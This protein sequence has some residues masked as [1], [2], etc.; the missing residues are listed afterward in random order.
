M[1]QFR[2]LLGDEELVREINAWIDSGRE[3]PQ[4][5][6]WGVTG[7][8]AQR[9]LEG[10]DPPDAWTEAVVLSYARP[11]LRVQ[12]GHL[13]PPLS[14]ELRRRMRAALPVIE[15]R[16]RAVGRVVMS[17][18]PRRKTAGTA[19][20]SKSR[21]AITTADVAN[22]VKGRDAA[23]EFPDVRVRIE[24]IELVDADANVAV[25]RL[26]DAD[27]MPQPI[28][29]TLNGSGDVIVA[30]HLTPESEAV[31]LSDAAR[32]VA[33]AAVAGL[34][35]A[36]GRMSGN[37]HD[38]T[39]AGDATG[40]V[41]LDAA[42]GA[43]VGMHPNIAAKTLRA[44][45]K[46]Y[47]A[48][49]TTKAI[50][51]TV[52]APMMIEEAPLTP[53]D[54]LDRKGYDPKFLG[55]TPK[56]RVKLPASAARDALEFTFNGKRTTELKYVHFSVV[57]SESRQLCLFSAVNIDGKNG[58]KAARK[59][60]LKDPRITD[61]QQ[62]FGDV[63]GNSPRFSRG[64]MTRREDPIWGVKDEADKG[65]RDSMHFTNAV[66]QMQPFN[67]PV[68][69]ALEDYALKNARKDTQR[70]TVITGPFFRKDDPVKFG[71][72]IPV[73]FWK[74][75][76]FIHDETGELTCTGYTMSQEDFLSPLEFVFGAFK[77]AQV[78]VALIEKRAKLD[79]HGL[80]KRDPL[81]GEESAFV[82]LTD[83]RDVRFI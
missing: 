59:G 40:G 54:Y 47:V 73:E 75:I 23:I 39:I 49:A 48:V 6:S 77:E 1:S 4:A 50:P 61:E 25:L 60:W 21:Y 57:M 20:L 80:A 5:R 55:D 3:L 12:N 32:R 63:Y 52:E 33:G 22:D 34:Y 72:R 36:P 71:V 9:A 28:P 76:I 31:G 67:A 79:F 15:R 81:A 82:P 24:G 65:N 29:I 83:V 27:E 10:G 16:L 7:D 66:P 51:E 68:W 44:K 19:W 56:L 69:L 13:Q 26:E 30:A 18:H 2:S 45:A 53:A 14:P 62:V 8:V 64:H 35:V 11:V 46:K 43:A 17:D 70:I 38:A 74:L 78:P 41:I 58:K 37:A 42:T